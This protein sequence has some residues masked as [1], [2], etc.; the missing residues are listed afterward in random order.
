MIRI[1]IKGEFA[2][3]YGPFNIEFLQVVSRLSG[4]RAW[5][6]SKSVNVEASGSNLKVLKESGFEIDWQDSTGA[7][8]ELHELEMLATQH[9]SAA[10]IDTPYVPN[11]NYPYLKHMEHCLNL[12]WNRIGYA[13]LLDM[14]LCKTAITIHNFGILFKK[15]LI[16]GVI[17]YAPKGVHLQWITDE[18]PKHIDPTI[19]LNLILWNKKE[20]YTARDF[21]CEGK[22]NVFALNIDSVITDAGQVAAALFVRAHAGRVFMVVDESHGIK[23][24]GS[25]RTREIMKIGIHCAFRRILTGTPISKS[26]EDLWSQFMFLDPRI[27]GINHLT[28]F[29]ARFCQMGGFSHKVVVGS[30]NIE[31][32]YR[33][34]A[35]HSYRLTKAEATDLPPKVYAQRVYE[36]D[37]KTRKHYDDLK[38]SFMTDLDSGTTIDAKNMLDC[39]IKLQQLLSGYQTIDQKTLK[40]ERIS[41]QRAKIAI[42]MLK[43]I[44][45]QTIVWAV[46]KPDI[47]ILREMIREELKEEVATLDEIELYKSR[48]RRIALLNPASGGTGLNLQFKNPGDNNAIYYNNTNRAIPR[49]QSED[50]I[51]RTGMGGSAFIFDIV[52][53]RTVDAGV[54]SNLRGKK[55]LADLVL[56]DIRRIISGD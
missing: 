36:M 10:K 48:K 5:H 39:I 16:T 54:L 24:Y 3:I 37:D 38:H 8:R 18:I 23:N 11:S 4:R 34:I 47:I 6:G 14:G 56:D 20:Q 30:K 27:I 26:L 53:Y 46:F 7:L 51:W 55:D 21:V 22:L 49:W 17:I 52:C 32:F 19:K 33:L 43:Q 44:E 28:V 29:K 2:S 45:G 35:P 9:S 41:D 15:G 13:L 12:S 42:D 1:E 31:E 50:R 25:E 40:L